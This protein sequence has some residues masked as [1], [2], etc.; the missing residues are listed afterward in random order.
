MTGLSP[1]TSRYYRVRAINSVGTGEGSNVV[2]ET[3]PTTDGAPSPPLQLSARDNGKTQIDLSWAAPGYTGNSLVTGY[4]IEVS[5]DGGNNWSDLDANTGTTDTTYEH[6]G[7]SPGT[8]RHY[9]VSAINTIGPGLVSEVVSATTTPRDTPNV[10]NNLRAVPGNNSVTLMWEAPDD[11]GGSPITG[12]SWRLGYPNSESPE[13]PPTFE[14][15]GPLLHRVVGASFE[16]TIP[17]FNNGNTYIFEVRAGN[18]NGSGAAMQVEVTLPVLRSGGGTGQAGEETLE[19]NT[20]PV[21]SIPL[22]DQTA[23][24]DMPFHYVI[25][26]GSFTDADDDPL[27]YSAALGDGTALPPWLTFVPSTGAF[28]GTP[29]PSDIARGARGE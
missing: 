10:P 2:T 8:T 14:D 15:W 3:T 26:E 11:D 24:V 6:T 29:G 19:T 16:R 4:K 1:G 12:Y 28:T 27:T 25:P 9:R 18:G 7:L 21:V 5:V 22:V 23:S 13:S 17:G 20:P